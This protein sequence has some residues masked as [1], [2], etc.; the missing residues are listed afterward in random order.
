[1]DI[2]FSSLFY[3]ALTLIGAALFI[4]G[5]GLKR[6]NMLVASLWLSLFALLLQYHAAGG[7]I[8]GNYF[9][10]KNAAIYTI[11]LIVLISALCYLT[12]TLPIL[13]RKTAQR[14]VFIFGGLLI[15]GGL[16]LIINLWVNAHFIETK[17]PGSP[18]MQVAILSPLPYCSHKYIFYKVNT[19][20]S[21]SYLCPNYYGLIPS[22]GHLANLPDFIQNFLT[23][24]NKRKPSHSG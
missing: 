11:N 17:R 21:A 1:M 22:V 13:Q 8:I 14:G 9:N 7:D 6:L 4:V 24:R 19:D 2:L 10:Y 20:N 3:D 16:F 18:L 23:E 15:I 12:Y 5:F